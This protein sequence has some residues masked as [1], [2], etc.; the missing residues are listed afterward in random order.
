MTLG[1]DPV[2]RIYQHFFYLDYSQFAIYTLFFL[3]VNNFEI[4]ASAIK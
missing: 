1:L 2:H 4:E 3:K